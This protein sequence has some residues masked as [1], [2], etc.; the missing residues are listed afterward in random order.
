MSAAV[1]DDG[2]SI[3]VPAEV[4]FGQTLDT[5]LEDS[6]LIDVPVDENVGMVGDHRV[7]LHRDASNQHPIS[8]ITGLEDALDEIDTALSSRIGQVEAENAE[9]EVDMATAFLR[10]GDLQNQVDGNITTWFYA[11]E[12]AMNLPPVTLDPLN[13][14]DTGWDTAEKKNA[15]K[16]DLYYNTITGYAYRFAYTSGEYG[17]MRITDTDVVRALAD[18]ARAQ[19]TADSKRRVFY[20]TPTPP[21]D[22]GDLWVQG[23][24]GDIFVCTTDKPSDG[25]YSA[26]DWSL[27]SKYTDDT[28]ADL[29]LASANGKNTVYHQ[30]SQPTGGTYKKGDTW[31][32][33]DDGYTMYT[34]DG[35]LWIKEQF[36]NEAIADLSITNAK[37]ANA[38]IE[39]S[40]IKSVDAGKI[41]TGTLDAARIGATSIGADKIKVNEINIGAAQITSGTIDTARIPNLSANKITSDTINIGRIPATARNDTYITDIGSDGIRVHDSH[42]SNNSVV[43][44]SNGMEVFV[45]GIGSSDSVAFYGNTARVGKSGGRHIEVSDGGMQVF[46]SSMS[47]AH[48][49]YANGTAQSG[50]SEAPYYTLGHRGTGVVGNYSLVSGYDPVASGWCS[51]AFGVDTKATQ[52]YAHA[53]GYET[54][55]SGIASHAEGQATTASST[56]SHAEG[57]TTTASGISSHAEGNDTVASGWSAH[58]EGAHT[59]ASGLYSHAGGLYTKAQGSCQTAI[60]LYNVADSTSLFIIGNGS[61]SARA[62]AFSVDDYGEVF[63]NGTLVHSSDRRLK[64][65]ISYVGDEAVEFINQLKPAHY[66]KDG[67]KHVGFY[68]QDIKEVDKW[69]CMTDEM[70]GYMT[71]GYMELLAPMV[72]YIQRLEKRIEELER[73]K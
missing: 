53:E 38:T 10:I 68:A 8:A 52:S 7:L 26:S 56:H 39:Y 1:I 50:T 72:A 43:I 34:Y 27:A 48:I 47:M 31:F 4:D 70:N 40:K 67:K 32:D 37:I 20:T 57:D 15:H 49:G 65:H 16:G 41:T 66:I 46:A 6:E 61:S 35:A 29:A 30:A 11:A 42:T 2:D 33:T 62:N 44:N 14:Y 51:Q 58:A 69:G 18:A 63:A 21:Y 73:S 71:L 13:P 64:D 24:G 9:L 25:S 19:D 12:P 36:G 28:V 23:S 3:V 45:G 5:E 55:A 22:K 54:T 60:G 59:E 17:W